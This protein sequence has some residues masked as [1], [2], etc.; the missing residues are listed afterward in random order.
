MRSRY[1]RDKIRWY[2]GISVLEPKFLG[3]RIFL[4][5]KSMNRNV[6]IIKIGSSTLLT[7]RYCVDEFRLSHIAKQVRTLQGRGWSIVLV[8]SGAVA[9]GSRLTSNK[10]AA[11][12]IGQVELISCTQK[13]F[14]TFQMKIA[15]ILL[16]DDISKNYERE[17]LL[18][19]TCRL[20][21]QQKIIPVFNEN[22]ILDLYSFGG[23]DHLSYYL[24]KLLA[25]TRVCI[26]S[27]WKTNRFCVG[28]GKGKR[29]IVERLK[30][31][32]IDSMIIDGK[33]HNCLLEAL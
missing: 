4:W 16:T 19:N 31:V 22:D 1:N 30:D 10:M 3:T 28:G 11:A 27:S 15:Q 32:H 12:G 25:A 33:K 6:F 8:L 7:K 13:I 18:Q 20:Y 9:I 5:G 29:E 24:A 23:N 26:L 17:K 21:F 14:A 2:H